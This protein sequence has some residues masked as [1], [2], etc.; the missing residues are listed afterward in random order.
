MNDRAFQLTDVVRET[1]FA[2]HCYFGPGHLEKVYENALAHRLGKAGLN[3]KQQHPLTV[4]DEDGTV[5]GEYY[6]DMLVEDCLVLELN[7]AK[8]VADEYIAQ[9]LGYL[10]AAGLVHG[11]VVNFGAPRFEIRKLAM[12]DRK[13][14]PKETKRTKEV[15]D[16][17]NE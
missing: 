6:A 2:V 12:T 8:A 15:G 13:V 4:H 11:A 5:V 3:V 1:G 14:W 17:L 16:E 7:A 9:M 10:R